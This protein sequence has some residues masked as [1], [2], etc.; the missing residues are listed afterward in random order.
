MLYVIFKRQISDGWILKRTSHSFA[1]H[2]FIFNKK[3]N[4]FLN[5]IFF[6]A[7]IC[8]ILFIVYLKLR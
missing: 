6:I 3:S 1:F 7:E 8:L 5:M 2:I 4:Y